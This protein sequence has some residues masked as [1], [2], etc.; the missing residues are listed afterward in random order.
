MQFVWIDPQDE[1]AVEVNPDN[2]RLRVHRDYRRADP[3]ARFLTATA[4]WLA[5]LMGLWL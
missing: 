1:L 3:W 5:A 2:N 4:Q